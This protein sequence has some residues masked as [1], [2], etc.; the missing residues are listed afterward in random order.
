MKVDKVI[1]FGAEEFNYVV[2]LLQSALE[3]GV[4]AQLVLS[5]LKEDPEGVDN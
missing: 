3:N 1:K 5:K 4:I 2:K